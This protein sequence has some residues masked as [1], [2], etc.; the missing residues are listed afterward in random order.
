MNGVRRRTFIAGLGS[1]AAWPAAARAQQPAKPV[2]GFLDFGTSETTNLTAFREGLSEGGFI[3]GRNLTIEYRFA[4][5][6]VARLQ[7][8]AADLVRRRVAVIAAWSAS[9]AAR[10]VRAASTTIPIVFQTGDDPVQAGLVT[11]LNR[12]GGNITGI[13]SM[14]V[15]IFA[16]R[17]QLLHRVAPGPAS[18]A[19]LIKPL[20]PGNELGSGMELLLQAAQT[21]AALLGRQVEFLL[22]GSAVEIETAFASL[23][24]KRVGA[25]LIAPQALFAN[26]AVQIATL[27]A[28]HAIP[29]IGFYRGFAEVGGLMTYG[30]KSYDDV[31][32]QGGIYVGRI[33][34][35]EN[36]A[37]LPVVQPTK[38]ELVINLTTA[39]A[40]GLTIPETLLAT[41]DE[42]IQ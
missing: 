34:K 17:L 7:E 3:E 29:A 21:S 36:P 13:T 18:I 9:E 2:I 6:D 11:S 26:R 25:L 33:L 8:L 42:V 12:P 4:D 27:A 28:R 39:K 23:V 24:Q 14:S 5:G 20:G 38:F 35:G 40:F 22:A 16:K 15:E 30:L 37:D 19:V 32:R 1:A 41:A 31:A 10:A